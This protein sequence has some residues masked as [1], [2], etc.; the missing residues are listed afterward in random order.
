MRA[1]RHGATCLE[2]AQALAKTMREAMA[3]FRRDVARWKAEIT[4]LKNEGDRDLIDRLQKWI[5][6]ADRIL[7]RW[8]D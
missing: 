5:E 8:D 3:E 1:N 6:E 2:G 7:D 4:Q